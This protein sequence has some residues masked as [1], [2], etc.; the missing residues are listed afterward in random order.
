MRIGPINQTQ[1][2]GRDAQR[3]G[4]PLNSQ[5]HILEKRFRGAILEEVFDLPNVRYGV[6]CLKGVRLKLGGV[7]VGKTGDSTPKLVGS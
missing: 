1:Q 4:R 7:Y 3:H 6:P 2:V 5:R